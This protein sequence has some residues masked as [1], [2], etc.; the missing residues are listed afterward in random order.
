MG[1]KIAIIGEHLAGVNKIYFNDQKV[2]LNPNFVTDNAIILT[3][4]SGIP[5]EKQDLIKLYT[6]N[7]SCYY[8]F[9]TKVPVPTINSMTCEYIKEGILPIFK[10]FI[11]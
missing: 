8:T 6:A 3:I 9:E 2:K 10:G 7:D 5:D 1:D 11:L 4:P